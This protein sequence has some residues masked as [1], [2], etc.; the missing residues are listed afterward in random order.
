M[1]KLDITVD[2][3]SPYHYQGAY[4][5]MDLNDVISP[6][7]ENSYIQQNLPVRRQSLIVYH[8]KMRNSNEHMHKRHSSLILSPKDR[9]YLNTRLSNSKSLSF[10][11]SQPLSIQTTP[12]HQ[13]MENVSPTTS[14]SSGTDISME[15]LYEEQVTAQS[16]RQ[17]MKTSKFIGT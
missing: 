2:G 9:Q 10:V 3:D 14:S 8:D 17:Q 11:H 16:P 7:I 4:A 13:C 6:D 1:T 5:S 12:Q 15:T